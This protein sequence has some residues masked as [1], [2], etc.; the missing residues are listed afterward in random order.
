LN[1]QSYIFGAYDIGSLDVGRN[2]NIYTSVLYGAFRSEGVEA[3]GYFPRETT[4]NLLEYP[5]FLSIP[6]FKQR[7]AELS[8][9][10]AGLIARLPKEVRDL[11]YE[12]LL[13]SSDPNN[14]LTT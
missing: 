1:R 13:L 11:I 10:R 2:Q 9:A 4:P 14:A 6:E 3:G 12:Q 7:R 8:T 5:H